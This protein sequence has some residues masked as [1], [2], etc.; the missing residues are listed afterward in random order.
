MRRHEAFARLP[1][2]HKIREKHSTNNYILYRLTSIY[3]LSIPEV[4]QARQ[5]L[6][7]TDADLAAQ[8]AYC[9]KALTSLEEALRQGSRDLSNMRT[10]ADLNA[11]RSDPRFQQILDKYQKKEK[12][13]PD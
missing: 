11:I 2:G 12:P 10:D 6:P 3:S 5:P 7:L 8:A 13:G 9:D 1:K 4:A